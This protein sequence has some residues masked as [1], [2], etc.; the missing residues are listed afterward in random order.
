MN[1]FLLIFGIAML[2]KITA[3]QQADRRITTP[4]FR[5]AVVKID[6]TPSDSQMLL[7]YQARKSIGV[8]DH[9]FS[10]VLVLDDG[11]TQFCL[12]SS[13]ICEFSPSQ[14]D[15]VA[16]MLKQQLG[17]NPVNF[18]WSATHTHS[19]PEV[20]PPG[21]AAAFLGDRYKHEFDVNYQALV[22]QS[23]IKGD[24]RRHTKTHSCHD[25]VQAGAFHRQISIAVLLMLMEKPV[26]A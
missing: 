24:Q 11:T 21:L 3:G 13:D 12:V 10:R 14:Y 19:A 7:G 26:L 18:W 25:L 4:V 15:R 8:H 22:E 6:I 5:A 9:I 23:V 20:G 1:R 16:K 2:C 17:I